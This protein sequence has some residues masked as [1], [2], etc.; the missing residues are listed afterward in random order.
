MLDLTDN[1]QLS[2]YYDGSVV[3]GLLLTITQ[4]VSWGGGIKTNTIV[5]HIIISTIYHFCNPE[6]VLLHIKD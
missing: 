1:L 5:E 4:F 3:K 6:A 2:I